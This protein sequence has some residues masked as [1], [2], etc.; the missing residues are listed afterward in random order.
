[1]NLGLIETGKIK[2]N[3]KFILSSGLMRQKRVTTPRTDEEKPI[4][5]T[6]WELKLNHINPPM[7]KLVRIDVRNKF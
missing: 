6:V 4:R 3:S 7:N 2:N 1:M 5:F